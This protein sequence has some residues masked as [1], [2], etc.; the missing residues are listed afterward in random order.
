M[1]FLRVKVN[2]Q[3]LW[4][5]Y[6]LEAKSALAAAILLAALLL[7]YAVSTF[8]GTF[9][10]RHGYLRI[11]YAIVHFLATSG[12]TFVFFRY[13]PKLC[14]TSLFLLILGTL[15]YFAEL[16][17]YGLNVGD[18]TTMAVPFRWSQVIL[19]AS[20]LLLSV[21]MWRDARA[22]KPL[23]LCMG[24]DALG[25][26]SMLLARGNISAQMHV[27]LSVDIVSFLLY[28]TLI[29]WLV[30]FWYSEY[31]ERNGSPR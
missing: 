30:L 25:W 27:A 9:E 14:A 7:L 26:L 8:V 10:G 29:G 17:Q 31:L 28:S 11:A 21:I 3:K 22:P 16:W 6:T 2:H 24:I 4:R 15:C 12:Y 19:P 23:A 1:Q 5:G 20:Y 18:F 13:A